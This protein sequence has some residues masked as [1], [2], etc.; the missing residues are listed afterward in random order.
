MALK[1]L[2]LEKELKEKRAAL[3]DLRAV[4]FSKRE[5][6]L[7]KAIDEANTAE[8]RAVVE[9]AIEEFEADT[10]R[11]E[12]EAAALES[13]ISEI[14]AEIAAMETGEPTEEAREKTEEKREEKI[15]TMGKRALDLASTEQR[16]FIMNAPETKE[17]LERVKDAITNKR[18]IT[19]ANL[20]VPVVMLD[21]IRENIFRYSKLINRVRLRTI[22][23]EARQT[24]AGT[25]PEAVWTEMCANINE[26][27]FAFNQV[28]LDGYKV[29]G[30]VP[31]CNAI[32]Q[33]SMYDLAAEIIDML[34]QSIGYALDKAILYGKGSASNMPMGIVTRLAQTTQPENY[35]A[36]APA[37][38]NLSASNVVSMADASGAEFYS[39]F[40]LAAAN[41]TNVYARGRR[42]WAMNSATYA[43]LL[44]KALVI[45]ASGAI[46]AGVNGTMPVVGGDID[47]LEFIPDGDIIGGYG[48]LYLL[49]E[50]RGLQIDQSEHVQ[51]LQDNTVF[52]AKARYDG[53]PVIPKAFVAINING[54]SVTTSMT[55]APDEANQPN[56]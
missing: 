25:V 36:N 41:T 16:S 8:E 5:T 26:L 22:N 18:A 14:E 48:D 34:G 51:F 15:I 4:D 9:K 23:G 19:G 43:M 49:G 7:E 40:V 27:D 37:W 1:M 31:V 53:L 54:G 47:V 32:L 11:T 45:D 42:F 56:P 21:I 24:I 29:A 55:F 35:P 38:T 33:D 39:A 10:K 12:E 30:Y 3:N 13:R 17:F 50:R 28:T 2:M 20:T 6:E 52:R 44:S 46:V